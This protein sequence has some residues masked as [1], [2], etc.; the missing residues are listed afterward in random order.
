MYQTYNLSFREAGWPEGE[1]ITEGQWLWRREECWVQKSLET[2]RSIIL[3]STGVIEIGRKSARC[4]G[5]TTFGIG[6]M[7][8][9]FHCRGTADVA[10][11]RC[12]L[13]RRRRS[14]HSVHGE[15]R[16]RSNGTVC[17]LTGRQV[18]DDDAWRARRVWHR[19]PSRQPWIE[20]QDW[21]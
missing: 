12:G 11:E 6:L 2:V 9:S 8:A 14:C 21:R 4:F 20:I 16:F 18:V 5:A 10:T 7:F 3:V 17:R 1:L 19:R 13:G 15:W